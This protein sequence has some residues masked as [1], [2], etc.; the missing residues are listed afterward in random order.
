MGIKKSKYHMNHFFC[1]DIKDIIIIFLLRCLFLGKRLSF[2]AKTTIYL[3]IPPIAKYF[4]KMFCMQIISQNTVSQFLLENLK[5]KDKP[6]IWS[7]ELFI[8]GSKFRFFGT[9]LGRFRKRNYKIFRRRLTMV[10]DIFGLSPTI[11][12]LPTAWKYNFKLLRS[13]QYCNN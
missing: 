8:F 1:N 10:V 13:K 2:C 4:A 6:Q 3:I 9:V 11:K 12:K 5:L 7:F